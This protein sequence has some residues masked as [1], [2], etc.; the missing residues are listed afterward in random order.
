MKSIKQQIKD[1][2]G[3]H[4]NLFICWGLAAL[5]SITGYVAEF[6]E[7][8]VCSTSFMA[9]GFVVIAVIDVNKNKS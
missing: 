7:F 9:A 1:Q 6:L 2:P 4:L 5:F 3:L 8:F